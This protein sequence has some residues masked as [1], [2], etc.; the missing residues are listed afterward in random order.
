M[1]GRQGGDDEDAAPINEDDEGI[2]FRAQFE[3]GSE[4]GND[5]LR[6]VDFA[7]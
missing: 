6:I 4:T 5:L 7:I 1:V 3:T 2:M